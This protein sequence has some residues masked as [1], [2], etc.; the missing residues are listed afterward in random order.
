MTS[1]LTSAEAAAR[2]GVKRETLYAYV[3]RGL[4]DRT[5]SLD[6]RTSLFDAR[7]VDELRRTRRRSA[8]GELRTVITTAI[9]ELDEEGHRYRGV[10]IQALAGARFEAVADWL[11]QDPGGPSHDVPGPSSPSIQHDRW[12]APDHLVAAVRTA[13]DALPPDTPTLDRV[14]VAVAV[15]SALDPMRHRPLPTAHARAGRAMIIAMTAALGPSDRQ[16][17]PDDGI[18]DL[19]ARALFADTPLTPAQRN[20]VDLVLVLLADHGLAASTFAAR[21]AASVRADPYSIVAAGLGSVGGL[22]HGAA[23][24]GVHRLFVEAAAVGVEQAIGAQLASGERCP[25]V[26]HT[27]YRSVDPREV[28]L[29]DA[30]VTAWAGHPQVDTVGEL[31][32][33]LA[34]HLDLVVN[35]D[36]S[37]G[38]LSWLAGAPETTGEAL[39]AVARVVGWIAH[40]IEEFGER[41][42]R[43]RPAARYV[44][45]SDP[46][47]LETYEAN[48]EPDP[49]SA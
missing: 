49:H 30:L 39:F 48:P 36:F 3:S 11:W 20:A 14:R 19:V 25:G 42:V 17:R 46:D 22:L 43:F 29:T 12:A 13:V 15:A 33:Q 9:T 40:G 10:P 38:A 4:L 35:V 44:T 24:L 27:I 45:Q 8:K 18:A 41:P 16:L 2:L 47:V 37:I 31:R 23:S 6:G 28:L 5:L 7:Q 32:S 21:I 1:Q 26:G 34:Q